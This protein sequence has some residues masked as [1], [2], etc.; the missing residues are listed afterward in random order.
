MRY[1][2]VGAG[3]AGLTAALELSQ[4]GHDVVI[5]EAA[6]RPGGRVR[7]ARGLADGQAQ[8]TVSGQARESE[9]GQAQGTANERATGEAQGTANKRATGEAQG[10]ANKRATRQAQLAARGQPD[11]QANGLSEETASR[12]ANEHVAEL[13]AERIYPGQGLMLDLCTRYGLT[14]R[15]VAPAPLPRAFLRGQEQNTAD[16]VAALD[17]RLKATPPGDCES[18]AQWMHRARLS[19][20]ERALVS[21]VAQSTPAAPLRFTPAAGFTASFHSTGGYE[22]VGGNDLLTTAMAQDLEVHLDS[23]A[24]AVRWDEAR[25]TVETSARTWNGD[26]VI[27]AVPGPQLLEIAFDPVL[28]QERVHALLGLRFGEALRVVA[29]YENEAFD[30]RVITDTEFGIITN[31]TAGQE[32]NHALLSCLI[33]ADREKKKD[34]L[35]RLDEVVSTVVGHRVNRNY[36]ETHNWTSVVRVPWGDQTNTTIP[37][38]ATPLGKTVYFAGEHTDQRTTPGGMNGAVAS[39]IRAAREISRQHPRTK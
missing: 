29:R 3:L 17:V 1:I 14:L 34:V 21:A 13:G 20:L 27:L 35:S 9:R 28:D 33:P 8:G 23:R 26:A 15:E 6:D 31:Q 12:P 11:R 2:V 37:K 25:V 38:L 7:T 32:E 24:I 4:E 5:L 18:L 36:G 16:L 39:G 19:D 22:I 10:T 30:P